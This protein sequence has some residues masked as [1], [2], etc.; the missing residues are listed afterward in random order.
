MLENHGLF[1]PFPCFVPYFV[2]KRH[3]SQHKPLGCWLLTRHLASL[4]SHD[5]SYN[6]GSFDPKNHPKYGKNDTKRTLVTILAIRFIYKHIWVITFNM[7]QYPFH[8]RHSCQQPAVGLH[9]K[10]LGDVPREKRL[11]GWL[12]AP[13]T[14]QYFPLH[15]I[16]FCGI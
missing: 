12:Y 3:P 15:Y 10:R 4:S 8:D 6:A 11:C 13:L 9:L 5:T 16:V 1:M 7:V 2:I 14:P